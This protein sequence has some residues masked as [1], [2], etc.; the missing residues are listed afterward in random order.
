MWIFLSLL[1]ALFAGLTATVSKIGLK[2]VDSS[3]GFAIQAVVILILTWGYI[4][5]SGKSRE[6]TEIEPKAW[7]WLLLSGVITTGAYLAYFAA[8]KAGDVSRVAPIDRLSLVFAIVFA[9]LFLGDRI[10]GPTI[11]GASLMAIGALVI[12]VAGASSK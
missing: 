7:G 5:V 2:N 10:N 1:S 9:V 12:A 11:F 4:G 6:L 8:I 3:V